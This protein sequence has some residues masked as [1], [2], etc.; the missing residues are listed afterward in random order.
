MSRWFRHYAGMMRD[1]KLVRISIRSK[2]PIERVIWVWGAI[3]ESAA[4]IDDGGRFDFD[5]AEAAYFLRADEDDILAV[6]N[7]LEGAGHVSESFV[8]KWGDRQFQSDRSAD[9]QRRY[10]ERQKISDSDGKQEERECDSDAGVTSP[11]RHRDGPETE[12]ETETD[13]KIPTVSPQIV[14]DLWNLMASQND[15]SKVAKLTDKRRRS[16]QARLKADGL[17][18]IQQA[19]GKIPQSDFLC[20]RTGDWSADFDFLMQPDSVTKILEG[21]YDARIGNQQR[22]G[23]A[24]RVGAGRETGSITERAMQRAAERLGVEGPGFGSQGGT[25]NALPGDDRVGSLP[26]ARR[27]IGND[28]GRQSQLAYRGSDGG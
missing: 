5:T 2:Q 15:L 21:K 6:S 19:I 27:S 13:K 18:L 8:V 3:L 26:H 9:R 1:D 14:V 24:Q 23:A 10:R 25:S 11:K 28:G 16:C 17:E 20:G 22:V 7:A 4:E 12:T